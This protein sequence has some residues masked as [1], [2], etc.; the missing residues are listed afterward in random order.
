M[1]FIERDAVLMRI[2]PGTEWPVNSGTLK[3]SHNHGETENKRKQTDSVV[4]IRGARGKN[5]ESA[6]HPGCSDCQSSPGG[7]LEHL[8]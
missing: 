7:R 6:V 2:A 8:R 5:E 1:Q 3:L 4:P